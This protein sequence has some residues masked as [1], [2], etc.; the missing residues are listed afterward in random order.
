MYITL[1]KKKIA[2]KNLFGHREK[3]NRKAYLKYTVRIM[4]DGS[5]FLEKDTSNTIQWDFCKKK[6][7]FTSSTQQQQERE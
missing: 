7:T 1:V 5:R 2:E 4:D 3:K 6:N